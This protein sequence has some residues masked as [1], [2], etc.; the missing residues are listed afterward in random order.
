MKSTFNRL[1]K[2]ILMM[3]IIC[4]LSLLTIQFFSYDN[5]YTIYTSKINNKIKF[6]PFPNLE[7]NEKGIVVL[8]NITSNYKEVEIL[9][10]G[11]S[12][13]DFIDDDEITIDVYDNDLI[14]IDGTR[15]N[16]KLYVKVVGVS[17][18]IETPKLDTISTTSQS[19]EILGKVQLK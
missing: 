19:I 18:N 16:K 6:I 9:L 8:K 1:E 5:K 7:S 15:Y 17:N 11:E 10:N 3:S 2:I 14:E 12:V 4:V 13:G